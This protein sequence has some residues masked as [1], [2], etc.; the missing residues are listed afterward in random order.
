MEASLVLLL[1][2]LRIMVYSPVPSAL[3]FT[4][5]KISKQLVSNNKGKSSKKSF[6]RF[7][8]IEF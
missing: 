6:R 4:L 1:L 5:S 8:I 7:F 3:T 2:A